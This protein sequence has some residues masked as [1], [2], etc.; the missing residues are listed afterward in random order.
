M[1]VRHDPAGLHLVLQTDHADLSGQLAR[2]WGNDR[3]DPP[4]PAESAVA[5]AAGHDEGWREWEAAPRVDPRTARPYQFTEMDLRVHHRF[6]GRGVGRVAE[7]D[8]YAGLL[9]SMHSVG[10]YRKRFGTNP[11]LIF[12]EIPPEATAE[13]DAYVADQEAFQARLREELAPAVADPAG[14]V[15]A[16]RQA[17]EAQVWTNYRLLQAWD[18]LSLFFC[19][20]RLEAG[21]TACVPH[22]PVRYG[23]G[24]QAKLLLEAVGGDAVTVL[25][26]PFATSPLPLRLRARLVE[27]RDYRDDADFQRAFAAAEPF[28][29]EFEVRAG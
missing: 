29:E 7:R 8:R 24:E 12:R 14:D 21:I 5:A 18:L 11:Q 23:S 27:D 25:P 1:I 16:A 15:V 19:T 28:V 9:V 3:F 10:L 22:V 2:H 13:I 6:Y 4:R 17:F 20:R 26:Y